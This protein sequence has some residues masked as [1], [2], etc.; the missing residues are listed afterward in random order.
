[1]SESPDSA[2]LRGSVADWGRFCA[3]A[4]A[5]LEQRHGESPVLSPR[6]IAET[7]AEVLPYPLGR[8]LL[9]RLRRLGWLVPQAVIPF[10]ILDG[11]DC[12]A[13]V[14]GTWREVVR[15]AVFGLPGQGV[16]YREKHRQDVYQ[17][18]CSEILSTAVDLASLQSVAAR[19][20]NHPEVASDSVL[21]SMVRAF[22]AER[23]AALQAV[24]TPAQKEALKAQRSKLQRAFDA[25]GW[26][27]Y[28]TKEALLPVLARL[29]RDFDGCLAQFE[30]SRALQLLDK[31]RDLRRRYPVH[32][33]AA[34]L[35]RCEEQ[36]DRLLKRAGQYRRQIQGLSAQ[37]A[38][39]AR[40]GD[41][42]TAA[43]VVRRLQA[44]NTLLPNLLPARELER[45]Q[46]EI[47]HSGR[48]RETR[49]LRREFIEHQQKVAAKIRDLAGVIYRFH[50]LAG[51]LSPEHE[52]YR[53]ADLNYRRA[54]EE[55]RGMDTEWLSGLVLQLE[56][57]M[58]DFD[59]PTGD[60]H[61]QLDRFIASVRTA[62]N[63]LCL[64][65]RARRS[66]RPAP[67]L[68]SAPPAPPEGPPPAQSV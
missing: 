11:P 8:V 47:F 18:L 27:K 29:Q 26:S 22:I 64:E 17:Q 33:A 4:T 31:L 3:R 19:V 60:I 55:I 9:R 10:D 1:M 42:K 40:D 68:P 41:D 59:D 53:R 32:V 28:P 63:R 25:P 30:E 43:W 2:K 48:V 5:A 46:A 14:G 6:C 45:L 50:E 51:K 52:A 35:Q 24:M 16:P 20:L 57:L 56:T 13:G 23:E 58:E 61:N 65:I 66:K 67:N 34:D 44:I 37:G 12:P 39:A 54:V 15:L 7:V 36:Y 38:A 21:G 62:L 49:E